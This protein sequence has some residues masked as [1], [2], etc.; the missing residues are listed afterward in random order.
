MRLDGE[1]GAISQDGRG[2]YVDSDSGS[3]IRKLTCVAV[4]P[5]TVCG[6]GTVVTYNPPYRIDPDGRG[7]YADSDGRGI[8]ADSDGRGYY[9]DSDGRVKYVDSDGKGIYVDSDD[10]IPA[11]RA[12]VLGELHGEFEP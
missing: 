5:P 6:V 8:Y 3:Q 9:A 1:R 12:C 4:T 11:K 2:Y 7:Y 10:T